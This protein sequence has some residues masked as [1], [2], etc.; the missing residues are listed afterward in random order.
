MRYAHQTTRPPDQHQHIPRSFFFL[1]QIIISLLVQFF[2]NSWNSQSSSVSEIGLR[3]AICKLSSN[4]PSQLN[5]KLRMDRVLCIVQYDSFTAS[6][7]LIQTQ[8][9][10]AK[11][12]SRR[13]FATPTTT[14]KVNVIAFP[15]SQHV[16]F[17]LDRIS[18]GICGSFSLPWSGRDTEIGLKLHQMVLNARNSLPDE[19]KK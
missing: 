6:V 5:P 8:K 3:T 11:L 18:R 4:Q 12:S 7:N 10:R 19:R 17:F 14:A 15:H 2:C 9:P 16:I 13:G 1:Y